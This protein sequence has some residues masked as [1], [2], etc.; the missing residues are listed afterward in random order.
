MSKPYL[1]IDATKVLACEEFRRLTPIERG[2]VL[3]LA[4]MC[5]ANESIPGR[6]E[7]V[8][9]AATDG[10][11]VHASD[12]GPFRRAFASG[13]FTT[14]RGDITRLGLDCGMADEWRGDEE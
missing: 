14:A 10:H 6:P 12:I 3:T 4:L 7:D 8:V 13:F 2:Y 11:G 9:Q 5:A 1:V